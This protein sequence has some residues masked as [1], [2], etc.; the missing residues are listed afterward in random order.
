[1]LFSCGS[2][3]AFVSVVFRKRL[4]LLRFGHSIWRPL[5][6]SSTSYAFGVWYLLLSLNLALAAVRGS[7]HGVAYSF[8]YFPDVCVLSSFLVIVI[9]LFFHLHPHFR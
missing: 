1:M 8:F 6:G 7:I 5:E 3:V 4:V 9:Y 2:G